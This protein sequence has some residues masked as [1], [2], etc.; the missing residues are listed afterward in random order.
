MM[1]KIHSTFD[2]STLNMANSKQPE[3]EVQSDSDELMIEYVHSI[4]TKKEK[5]GII[6]L[7]SGAG[8][9]VVN[10]LSLL[11]Y[12][13][14][15]DKQINNFS[16][17]VKVTHR[18]TLNFKGV[19]LHPVF[20]VP[21]GPVNLHSISQLCDHGLKIS[22]K[23]NMIKSLP[24]FIKR[25]NLFQLKIPKMQE[26]PV[27][28]IV[29]GNHDWHVTLGHLS[30]GYIEAMLNTGRI[31]GKFTKSSVCDVCKH[32]KIENCPHSKKLPMVMTPFFKLQMDTLQ[33][34]PPNWKGN[35]YLLV[36]IDY[37]SR[38]NRVYPMCKKYEAKK[39]LE[40]YLDE[41]KKL[42]IIPAFFHS[43]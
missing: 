27:Y 2:I 1:E 32:A 14:G 24:L 12:P 18:R 25:G 10:N 37:F 34:S 16:S 22:T 38:F 29:T 5:E 41:I 33:V 3:P 6:Y 26:N 19:S 40:S 21:D 17:P 28:S 39:H 15:V 42:G 36:I 23:S 13:V 30:D 43:N 31:K 35:Q 7:D 20:C 11:S 9:T 4:E 8:Q